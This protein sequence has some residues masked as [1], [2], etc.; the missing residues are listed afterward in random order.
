MPTLLSSGVIFSIS[1]LRQLQLLAN[2]NGIT[3]FAEFSA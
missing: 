3:A 2:S 1:R